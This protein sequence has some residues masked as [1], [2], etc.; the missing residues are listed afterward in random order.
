MYLIHNIILI[1]NSSET[2]RTINLNHFEFL[3]AEDWIEFCIYTSEE[4]LLASRILHNKLF[5]RRMEKN[6]RNFIVLPR[7]SERS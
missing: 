1:Q 7:P 6:I 4:N 5:S 2:N 3:N